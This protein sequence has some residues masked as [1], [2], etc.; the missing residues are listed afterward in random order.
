MG[1][2]NTDTLT[3]IL[4]STSDTEYTIETIGSEVAIV[5]ELSVVSEKLTQQLL[6]E[7]LYVKSVDLINANTNQYAVF[8]DAIDGEF[9]DEFGELR[10]GATELV[11]E[12][13]ESYLQIWSG[14]MDIEQDDLVEQTRLFIDYLA[15][16]DELSNRIQPETLTA[17]CVFTA[18]KALGEVAGLDRCA[19]AFGVSSGTLSRYNNKICECVLSEIGD[20]KVGMY[21]G[22]EY[23]VASAN[24]SWL[25][26]LSYD[27]GQ[28][29]L[30]KAAMEQH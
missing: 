30:R 11:E 12:Y 15:D 28:E 17:G 26:S 2:D 9:G 21:G 13:A 20:G 19:E 7:G 6:A 8:V 14:D 27:N 23:M 16:N 29:K 22:N 5:S 10:T 25:I 24:P 1:S 18:G 3:E 4:D